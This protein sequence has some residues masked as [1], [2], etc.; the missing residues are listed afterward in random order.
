MLSQH[1]IIPSSRT[2]STSMTR[3]EVHER[4]IRNKETI[5]APVPYELIRQHKTSNLTSENELYVGYKNMMAVII[6]LEVSRPPSGVSTM[7]D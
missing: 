4:T 1:N 5:D 6:E 3:N 2:S 7:Q